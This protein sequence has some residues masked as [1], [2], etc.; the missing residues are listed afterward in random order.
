MILCVYFFPYFFYESVLLKFGICGFAKNS[1]DP[2]L[3]IISVE[4][5]VITV[6]I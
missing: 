3:H 6:R 1:L 4:Y 2:V 5:D